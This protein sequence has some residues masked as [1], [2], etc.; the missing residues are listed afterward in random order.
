[1]MSMRTFEVLGCGGFYLSQYVPSLERY[2]VNKEHLVWSKNSNETLKNVNYYLKNPEERNKIAL[3]GQRI[4]Y[5]EHSYKDKIPKL[6][7][8][9]KNLNIWRN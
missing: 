6:I 7:K 1:M 4:C 3:N 8:E 2:F 9:L 5:K